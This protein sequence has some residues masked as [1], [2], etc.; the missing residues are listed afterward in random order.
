M[1][2]HENHTAAKT[3]PDANMKAE[4]QAMK[5]KM[6]T[7]HDTMK[8]NDDTLDRL[9]SKM[10]AAKGSKGMEE[11]MAAVLNE[12]VAQRKSSRSAMM[13]MQ[14]E[15]MEHMMRHMEMHDTKGAIACPM[16]EMGMAHGTKPGETKPKS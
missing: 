14:P 15:M 4:C 7:M 8:A 12:L 5:A 16:M 3:G 13:E 9:V 6:Q 10:N 1:S 2:G 11:P